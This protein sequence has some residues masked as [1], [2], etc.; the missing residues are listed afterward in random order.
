MGPMQRGI[1]VS[2]RDVAVRSPY[3]PSVAV[4]ARPAPTAPRDAAQLQGIP[5]E[6]APPASVVRSLALAV[7]ALAM[8]AP[9]LAH[10]MPPAPDA[11]SVTHSGVGRPATTG[12]VEH[13]TAFTANAARIV[14][15]DDAALQQAVG[16]IQGAT[17]TVRLEASAFH[18]DEA[19]RL[20][21]ALIQKAGEQK[22]VYVLVDPSETSPLL[23]K[24]RAGGVQVK[25]YD[26]S[27][28]RMGF[29][30][31]DQTNLLIVDDFSAL[32]GA[33]RWD[34][35]HSQSYSVVAQG[36]A[37][38]DLHALWNESWGEAQP[39]EPVIP[40]HLP[41]ANAMVRVLDNNA[42]RH[43][44]HDALL[45]N[46]RAA[47]SEIFIEAF[48]LDDPE[49][50]KALKEARNRSVEVTVLLNRGSSDLARFRGEANNLGTA[51][52]FSQPNDQL[53]FRWFP[54]S[55]ERKLRSM[56]AEFDRH[57]AIVGSGWWNARGA[58]QHS[59]DLIVHD[60]SDVSMLKLQ[61]LGDWQDEGVFAPVEQP[62]Q[63]FHQ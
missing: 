15:G 63:A 48:A 61:M 34:G 18:G 29:S 16:L 9:A 19:E 32:T 51:I 56:V 43:E 39:Y 3:R 40:E 17:H 11:I 26:T 36:P 49:V 62:P 59:V 10:A 5:E 24:L 52:R 30:R 22:A 14:A 44:T 41:T 12:A 33:A 53:P 47:K 35:E 45:A 38:A 50:V 31:A 46:I 28:L 25:A 54:S 4:P 57:T 42:A 27:R 1:E 6:A 23:E 13:G 7:L 37:V 55:P 60:P 8:A 21:D 2:G 58:Q 20:A